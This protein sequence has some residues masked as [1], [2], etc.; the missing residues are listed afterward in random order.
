MCSP[1]SSINQLG[2]VVLLIFNMISKAIDRVERAQEAADLVAPAIKQTLN[3]R[4][5]W[6]RKAGIRWIVLLG[7]LRLRLE[8]CLFDVSSGEEVAA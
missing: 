8:G 1:V 5:R 7:D 4:Q 6:G 3:A 2:A